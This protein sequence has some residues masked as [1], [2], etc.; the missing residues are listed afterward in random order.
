MHT[1]RK[2]P[3]TRPS[4]KIPPA[5]TGSTLP[6]NRLRPQLA[7]ITA[8]IIWL[9]GRA[10]LGTKVIGRKDRRNDGRS[11]TASK[12]SRNEAFIENRVAP[13]WSRSFC[14]RVGILTS[15]QRAH[16]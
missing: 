2:L 11:T 14:D 7:G 8:Q 12:C 5:M 9:R 16:T 10:Y 4:A 13:P 6:P 15:Q 1:F 3:N